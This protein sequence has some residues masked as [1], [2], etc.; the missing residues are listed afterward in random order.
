MLLFCTSIDIHYGYLHSQPYSI[1]Q[2]LLSGPCLP[3]KHFFILFNSFVSVFFFCYCLFV[4]CVC[5]S[6][7]SLTK[8]INVTLSLQIDVRAWQDHYEYIAKYHL[9]P[10]PRIYLL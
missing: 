5:V 8:V 10:F 6:H 1:F 9:S 2:L 3:Y 4:L 7:K